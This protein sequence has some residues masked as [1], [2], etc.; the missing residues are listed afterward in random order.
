MLFGPLG[1]Q[2][3]LIGYLERLA[4]RQDNLIGQVLHDKRGRAGFS[5]LVRTT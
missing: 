1:L 2:S 5:T 3:Q 4:E